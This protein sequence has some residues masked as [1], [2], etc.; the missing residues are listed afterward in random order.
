L[1]AQLGS[2]PEP[3]GNTFGTLGVAK[4][5][6]IHGEPKKFKRYVFVIRGSVS[7]ISYLKTT[8]TTLEP[9]E[10]VAETDVNSFLKNEQKTA[11]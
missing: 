11:L 8:S 9:I 1:P 6:Q 5:V 3:I 4:Y 10:Q 2:N 7:R